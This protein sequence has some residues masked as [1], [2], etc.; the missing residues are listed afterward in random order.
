MD[1]RRKTV[2]IVSRWLL[3]IAVATSLA[4]IPGSL[5]AQA[6]V[7]RGT[8]HREGRTWVE[9]V[10]CGA[11]V[12]DGGR[13]ILKADFGSVTVQPGAGKEMNCQ[14]RLRAYLA[15]AQEAQ[16]ALQGYEVSLQTL[17]GGT[18]LLTGRSSHSREHGGLS[19]DYRVSVPRQFN[20]NLATQG[21]DLVVGDLDGELRGQ[22]AGGNIQTGDVTGPV[23]ANTSGGDIDLGNIGRQVEAHTAGGAIR[24]SNVK[25]NAVLE[26]SGGEI[27]AGMVEG[28]VQAAT[29]GGD[30]LL[31]G[32]TGPVRA[33]TA[34]GQIQIGQCDSSIR[35]QSAGGSI[36]L[37][38]ARG[39]VQAGT[40]GGSIDLFGMQSAVRAATT[41]GRIF[42]EIDASPK[43]FA[44]WELEA[45][46]GDVQVF[47]PPD[48]PLNLDAAIE[49]AF[50]HRI[51]SDFPIQ[52]Q[53]DEE[54]FRQRTQR[55]EAALNGGG[56]V[57][58][59]RTMMGNIEI[60][61]LNRRTIE[62]FKAQR[63]AFRR[64]WQ[65]LQRARNAEGQNKD[66]E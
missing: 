36:R 24:L 33:E 27:V 47:L 29:K 9:V 13:L 53:G 43:S 32:A 55:A 17:E 6:N 61:K 5:F 19:V 45:N 20:L 46:V 1:S 39:F 7:Q 15:N 62:E 48:L 14:V 59:I 40:A 49:Q 34:G 16:R 8:P 57:L 60:H 4:G 2:R 23:Y 65:E 52:I 41:A 42:A 10:T 58:R 25:G 66:K 31:R 21:G 26:T 22:T 37:Y 30:I 64:T 12:H 63:E 54:T 35:A 44:P 28:A 18:V 56:N 3:G 11:P 50:G 38:G 51:V